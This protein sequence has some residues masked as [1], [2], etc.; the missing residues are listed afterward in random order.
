MLNQLG[1]VFKRAQH[2]AAR[3][4]IVSCRYQRQQFALCLIDKLMAGKR[5]I[6]IDEANLSKTNFVRQ[7]WQIR[8]KTLR[9]FKNPL[10]HSISLIAA[11]DNLGA[12]YFS[13]SQTVNNSR[14][15]STFL[16][17]LVLILDAEDP[18]WR[19]ETILVLDG[20]LTHRSEETRRAMAALK[21]PA[22]IAGPYGFDASPCEKL[23]A[24]LKVGELNPNDIKT[25]KR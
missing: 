13:V 20:A 2:I 17:R 22:M 21:V 14:T 24:L 19:D 5:V 10:G 15:F 18:D 4:N 23:F 25:G 7:A 3:T 1:F 9:P 11:V 12:S 8:G 6:N 16:Q